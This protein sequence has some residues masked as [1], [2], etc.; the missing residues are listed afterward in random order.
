M[1]K[2]KG[3]SAWVLALCLSLI[4]IPA[5]AADSAQAKAPVITVTVDGVPVVF[6]KA[7]IHQ[8]GTVLAEAAPLFK[9]LGLSYR[10]PASDAESFSVSKASLY[11]EMTPGS[12]VAYVNREPKELAAAPRFVDGTLFVPLRWAAE[13]AGKSVEWDSAHSSIAIL[14]AYKVI[15]YYIS[16]GIYDR[17]YQVA[18][19]DASNITHIN[20]AFANIKDGEIVVGDP[21]ADTDKVFPGDCESEG[22]KHG[23]FNQL[24]RL[25]TV[26]PRL[27][28]LISVGGWTWSK[29]FS[30]VAVSEES[31]TKFAD[32][33]V[34]FVRDWGFDGVDLD[35]EYPVGGG[36]EGNINRPEDKQNYTLLLRK[37][38]EKLDAAGQADGKHYL[39]TIAA[40]ASTSF[41]DN[42]ELDQISSVVDWINVMTYDYHGGWD[43]ASGIN[44]PLY[45]DPKDPSPGS[46]N[47]YVAGTVH[48]F[49]D[50]GVPADKLVMGMPFYGRGWTKCKTDDNGLYQACGGV[51]KGT[52][53]AGALDIADIEDHYVNKNGYTRY[54]NDSTKTPWLFNPA[55]GTFIG[56]DDAES[57]SYKTRFIKDTGLAGAM[58]WDITSD[59]NGTLTGQLGKDLLGTP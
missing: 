33:A 10:A 38:R 50:A 11:I 44:S 30:D 54:W 55:D 23:N 2:M 16:W 3:W 31:R 39:L 32:S 26:N 53:E 8:G 59:K 49:L 15:A 47:T 20:Y 19:I 56:Y 4:S 41:I 27:Q 17:N 48:N 51:S 14:P 57:F 28:T 7:P 58:F 34:K 37:I 52:W 1:K 45:Y 13:T 29:W 42:T 22:C 25:K 6:S 36:L 18:D 40:G 5:Y 24:N 12:E 35:W 21:W 43:T 9:A 46:A